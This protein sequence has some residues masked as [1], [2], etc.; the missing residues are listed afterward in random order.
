MNKCIRV[1]LSLN[2]LPHT[3]ATTHNKPF[4]FFALQSDKAL[5]LV[6]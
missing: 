1:V 4:A 5:T 3:I 2:S 6:I